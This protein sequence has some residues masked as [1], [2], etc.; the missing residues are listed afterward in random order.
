[1]QPQQN[2][3]YVDAQ[4]LMQAAQ[5]MLPLKQRSYAII[6][7][8]EGSHVLDIGCGPGVDTVA[9]GHIVGAD[10]RVV[11]V[12][13]DGE[14]IALADQRAQAE[15][16]A[17]WVE[18]LTGDAAAL[19][20]ADRTFDAVRA[21]RVFQHLPAPER[22]LAEMVRV[23]KPGGVILLMDTDWSSASLSA[24]GLDPELTWKLRRLLVGLRYNGFAGCQ[25]YTLLKQQHLADVYADVISVPLTDW[26]LVRVI[27][28][29]DK[30]QAY[31]A[32]GDAGMTPEELHRV[33]AICSQAAVQ[34][35]FWGYASTVLA[36]AHKP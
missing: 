5:L 16:V 20:F 17:G 7:A 8:R 32:S 34:G 22:V 18:H 13:Y 9:L 10:G 31:A 1:M 24:P 2:P 21:E 19:P 4:Y 11:G 12:D 30:L 3:G 23:T 14:M 33:D 29:W 28:S 25:L 35:M 6:D 26:D 36:A 27:T 15:G